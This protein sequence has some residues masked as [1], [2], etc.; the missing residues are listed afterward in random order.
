MNIESTGFVEI[1]QYETLTR[2]HRGIDAQEALIM[3][4]MLNDGS[5][6][7]VVNDNDDILFITRWEVIR[8]DG[9]GQLFGV[10]EENYETAKANNFQPIDQ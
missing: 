1:S 4:C 3:V 5:D 9:V 2:F 10:S 6:I 8:T 7:C